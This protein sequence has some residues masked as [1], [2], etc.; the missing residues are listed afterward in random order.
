MN[1]TRSE[2]CPFCTATRVVVN[3][4]SEVLYV[5]HELTCA[6]GQGH[7]EFVFDGDRPMR[8]VRNSPVGVA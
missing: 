3:R 5:Y 6:R 7:R 1:V 2:L 4:N 8:L